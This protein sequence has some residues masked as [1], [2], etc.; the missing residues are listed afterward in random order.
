MWNTP[1]KWCRIPKRCLTW[2]VKYSP[3]EEWAPPSVDSQAMASSS[4]IR[5]VS[6]WFMSQPLKHKPTFKL[7]LTPETQAHFP[8]N[9][10]PAACVWSAH[11]SWAS[12]WN[13]CPLSLKHK[14]SSMCLVSTRL[15]CQP[16]KH[17][18]TFPESQAHFQTASNP[19]NTSPLSNCHTHL[20]YKPTFKLPH[21]SNTSPLPNCHTPQT[22]AHFQT[23]THPWNTSP[24]L[25]CHYPWNTSPLSN[26]HTLETQA[27]FQTA[28]PLKYKPTFNLS[29]TPEKQAHF[30][31]VTNPWN[32]SPL[33]NCHTPQTQ[34]HFQT[35]TNPWNTSPLSNCH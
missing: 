28:I 31:T 12:P 32:T 17:K 34:A 14:P 18:P 10:S 1:A 35:V 4:S 23:A 9:T 20:K 26:C 8:W 25:N 11:G 33:S 27:H 5:L 15:M 21:P 6:T 19:W 7:P 30:Q 29:L 2:C 13:T 24:L 22:Q 16:L 3:R